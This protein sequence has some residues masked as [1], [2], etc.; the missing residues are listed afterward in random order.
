[1]QSIVLSQKT[2]IGGLGRNCIVS[3]VKA[4]LPSVFSPDLK[5]QDIH[6]IFPG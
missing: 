3:Q 1:M 4:F 2:G 5:I 6:V